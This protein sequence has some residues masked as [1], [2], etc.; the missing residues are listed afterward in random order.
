MLH[1]CDFDPP[2]KAPGVV[3]PVGLGQ[4]DLKVNKKSMFFYDLIY[5]LIKLVIHFIGSDDEC[6]KSIFGN[7]SSKKISHEIA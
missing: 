7:E 5:L 3:D 4:Y 2:S 6:R 1:F